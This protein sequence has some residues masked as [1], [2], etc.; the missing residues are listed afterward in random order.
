[1]ITYISPIIELLSGYSQ[2]EVI[3][4]PFGEFVY[5]EDLPG[6]MASFQRTLSGHLEPYEFRVLS[7][8]GQIRRIHSSG[9]P[10]FEIEARTQGGEHAQETT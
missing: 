5:P 4:R 6:L 7:K 2:V 9:R 1:V 8:P 3:G 10:I